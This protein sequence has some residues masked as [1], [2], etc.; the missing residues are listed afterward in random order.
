M[1]VFAP[2][3]RAGAPCAPVWVAILLLGMPIYK[4][5]MSRCD[6]LPCATCETTRMPSFNIV[7]TAAQDVN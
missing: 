2:P 5:E 1:E 4:K 7:P 6:A 3:P